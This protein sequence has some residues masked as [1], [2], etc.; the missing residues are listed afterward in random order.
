M[1]V[2]IV[3]DEPVIRAAL[4]KLL[5]SR[6]YEVISASDGLEAS[7]ILQSPDAPQLIILDWQ[8]PG[9][10]G[11]ELCR[12]VRGRTRDHYSYI[13][14]LTAK[15]TRDDLLDGFAAGADDYIVKPFDYQELCMRLHA[16]KRI[17]HLQE[18][19]IA[20]REAFRHQSLRD[21]L[22]GLW[23][24][25]GIFDILE[26][27]LA[28]TARQKSPVGVVLLDLD[29]FKRVNDTFGHPAGDAVLREVAG[30]I[31]SATRSYDSI[32][33]QGG[34]EFLIVLPNCDEQGSLRYAER[35][36]TAI[37]QLSVETEAGPVR[38]TASM[39]V[40]VA[41]PIVDDIYTLLRDADEALYKAK[42]RGRNRIELADVANSGL[43]LSL[44]R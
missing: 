21:S 1:K 18:Q 37:G 32:G 25:A 15:N 19:L 14:L 31:R 9:M 16:G 43:S 34:E 33:R 2:L 44:M 7:A 39:G 3:D 12:E 5:C 22:T 26:R 4:K 30:T 41:G 24:C 6:G 27:E 20:T 10:N 35:I 8:M 29:H 40:A 11:I 42:R 13:I 38:I 36:R 23:N 28:R 17:L